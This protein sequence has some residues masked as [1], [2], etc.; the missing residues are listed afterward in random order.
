MWQA[1]MSATIN[2]LKGVRLPTAPPRAAAFSGIIFSILTI[3]SLGIIRLLIPADPAELSIRVSNRG[4]EQAIRLALNLVPFAGIAFLWFLGVLRSRLGRL[5]DQFFVTVLLGS[6]VLFVASLFASASSAEALVDMASAG[7]Q[8][9]HDEVYY[10]ARHLSFV[11]LNTFAIRMA[12]VFIFSVC[13]IAWRTRVFPRSL[14]FSG[15]ACGVVLLAVISN[16]LWIVLLFPLWV[17]VLSAHIL[18]VDRSNSNSSTT[19]GHE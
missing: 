9:G 8:Q 15:F 1:T 3:T 18:V 7:L 5:E 16:W 17:L 10:F 11:F 14:A 2:N 13:T 6:G 19:G 12:G 4:H